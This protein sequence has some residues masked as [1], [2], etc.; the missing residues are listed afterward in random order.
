MELVEFAD[1]RW[2]SSDLDFRRFT[3]LVCN[4]TDERDFLERH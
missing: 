1:R 3:T 2:V 4:Q